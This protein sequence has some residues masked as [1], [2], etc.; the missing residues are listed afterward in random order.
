MAIRTNAA[1]G[2]ADVALVGLGS[3]H[4]VEQLTRLNEETPFYKLARTRDRL[5]EY[6]HKSARGHIPACS[7]AELGIRVS[8]VLADREH[9]FAMIG[10]AATWMF[11]PLENCRLAFVHL[12]ALPNGDLLNK[13]KCRREARGSNLWPVHPNETGG[14]QGGEHANSMPCVYAAKV[15]LGLGSIPDLSKEVAENLRK[16]WLQ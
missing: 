2:F 16:E 13:L 9:R 1:A 12:N 3:T 11:S 4:T 10:L 7:G 8:S 15:Y 6:N 5:Q 14:F